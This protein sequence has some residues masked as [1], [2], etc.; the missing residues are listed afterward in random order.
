M[1]AVFLIRSAA[2]SLPAAGLPAV[3][4]AAAC[5][6]G[7]V[8]APA[9]GGETTVST[10]AELRVALAAAGPGDVVRVAPGTYRGGLEWSPKGEPG[11]PVTLAGADPADPAVIRGA[12]EGIKLT[13]PTHAVLTDLI[14]EGA[15]GNG[16]N[17]DDGGDRRSPAGPLTFRRVVVRGAGGA[18]G[19]LDGF[20][21]TGIDGLRMHDCVVLRW[22]D[23]GSGI[24]LV[25]CHDVAVRRCVLDGGAP[26]GDSPDGGV[27]PG[28]GF[29]AKGGCR[30]VLLENCRVTGVNERCVNLGGST[31]QAFFRPPGAPFEAAGVTVRGCELVGGAAAVAF[32]GSDGGRAE[33]CTLRGQTRFPFRILKENGAD[34]MPDTRG[35]V[36]AGNVIVWDAGS[37]W[38]LVNVGSGT[39]A[40]TFRFEDN[41]WFNASNPSRSRLN[42]LPAPETG[43]EYGVAPADLE[44]AVPPGDRPPR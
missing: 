41:I 37:V 7:A 1:L 33:G 17:A 5:A 38:T 29:Q 42:G 20:K 16:V 12:T 27:G 30:D 35:G 28:T 9:G 11:R 18:G 15:A 13:R 39:A 23:G 4:L 24:D 22:G 19:N 40:D 43:G 44:A 21:L 10:D 26:G 32:V 36:I 6:V 8:A 25:G 2:C 31:G 34:H 3:L 14:F